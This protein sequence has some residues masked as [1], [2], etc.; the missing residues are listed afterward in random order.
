[1]RFEIAKF[2]IIDKCLNYFNEHIIIIK[3]YLERDIHYSVKNFYCKIAIVKIG[4]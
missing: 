2:K 4:S 1:M 3:K